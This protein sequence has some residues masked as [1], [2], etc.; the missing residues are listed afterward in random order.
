MTVRE[1]Q[2]ASSAVLTVNLTDA[3]IDA[4]KAAAAR[5]LS[6][7]LKLHGFR[8]GKAPR[9]VVEAAIGAERLR[10]EAIEDLIPQQLQKLLE[11][12][13]LDSGRQ[14]QSRERQ[15]RRR[16]SR[17]RGSDHALARAR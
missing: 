12:H 6:K 2:A 9:P 10:S 13:E 1:K 11:E 16:G 8:P 14:P 15:R 4:A 7:D 5:R 17:G 3:E